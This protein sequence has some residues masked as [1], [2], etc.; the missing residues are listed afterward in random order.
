MPDFE[1]TAEPVTGEIV[2]PAPGVDLPRHIRIAAVLGNRTAV[3]VHAAWQQ[4]A[5]VHEATS[6]TVSASDDG[7]VSAADLR[8]VPLAGVTAAGAGALIPQYWPEPGPVDVNAGPTAAVLH[9]VAA[10]YLRAT[11]CGVP[12]QQEVAARLGV[13]K[14]TA[15]RWITRA[16]DQGLIGITAHGQATHLKE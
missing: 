3:T 4:H 10:W 14:G 6:V 13:P 8:T 16:R 5:G 7:P 12:A 9:A 15:V 1:V 2:S 11:A